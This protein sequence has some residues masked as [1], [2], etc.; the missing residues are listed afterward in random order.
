MYKRTVVCDNL[1]F[2]CLKKIYLFSLQSGTIIGNVKD[3]SDL[4]PVDPAK[5]MSLF[6][7]IIRGNLFGTFAINRTTGDLITKVVLDYE[8]C[9]NYTLIVRASCPN[10]RDCNIAS[11]SNT[12]VVKVAIRD[13]NDNAPQ[14]HQNPLVIT[15]RE[16]VQP[17]TP[18]TTIRAVDVDSGSYGVVRYALLE[19]SPSGGYFNL[20]SQ[21][22]VLSV[23]RGLDYETQATFTIVIQV[24]KWFFFVCNKF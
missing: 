1:L 18:I 8:M 14:F 3:N 7:Y 10:T 22:G 23:V 2:T 6:F 5:P 12:M 21:T 11:T 15:V 9:S 4:Q 16:D 20:N 24:R 13:V 19:E 17:N